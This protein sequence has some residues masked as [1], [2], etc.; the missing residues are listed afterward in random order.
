MRQARHMKKS[1][2]KR[3]WIIVVSVIA[4]IAIG[5]IF[6]FPIN[7]TVRDISGGNDTASDKLVKDELA[8]RI[9]ATK[10]GDPK[11]DDKV[12]K[13]V[14]DLKKTRMSDIMKA[15]ENQNKA[16]TELHNNTSLSSS[17]SKKVAKEI[18]S[19]SKYDKLRQ[20]VNDGDWYSAYSQYKSLS[21]NGSI[22]EL[23]NSLSQ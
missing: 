19:N 21:N 12:N 20:S 5:I 16:A 23:K 8:K 3:I 22:D 6:F 14:D 15:A 17:E 9:E 13:A 4:L 18:F 1:H 2:K 11:H 10:T 7:N